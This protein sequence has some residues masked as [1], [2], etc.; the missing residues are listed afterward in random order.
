MIVTIKT[1][2]QKT[3][4]IELDDTENVAALKQ[5]IEQEQ[6]P[7]FPASSLKL[8]YAGKI[9]NDSSP[10]NEYN[11]QESN[12]VVVMVSKSKPAKTSAPSSE[13]T[14]S[15]QPQQQTATSGATSATPQE[16]SA[17][18]ESQV[19]PTEQPSATSAA[20]TAPTVSLSQSSTTSPADSTAGAISTDGGDGQSGSNW[21]SS[22]SALVRG[23]EY[24]AAVEN[25][26]SMGFER[27][28]VVRALRASFNN[29][30]RA[31][32]YLFNGIPENVFEDTSAPAQPQQPSQEQ[33]QPPAPMQ[34]PAQSGGSGQQ[35]PVNPGQATSGLPAAGQGGQ[36]GQAQGGVS[37]LQAL[38][39]HP[40][41]PMLRQVLH[42]NP[43]MLQPLL[44]QIGQTNPGLLQ[45]ISQNQQEFIAILNEGVQ[46][47]EAGQGDGGAMGQGGPM[48]QGGHG[49]LTTIQVTA[50]EKEA[51]DRLKALGFEETLAVQ[52][53]FACDKNEELAANFLLQQDNE[54]DN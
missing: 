39:N 12:F 42:Q 43:A 19:E 13:G 40:L 36:A 47:G 35:P 54:D 29:P 5:K 48:D 30:D 53:Y 3:F 51:I 6:G 52:A 25:M 15:S 31:V 8:I 2:Q 32:E 18:R 46:R 24:E 23:S 4:K 7:A 16:S 50:Q 11:I 14:S 27:Q 20:P 37:Q 34:I 17:S 38:R 22:A 1:L 33:P 49:P 9:L 10:L 26:M 28:L 21:I 45:L 41:F 44:Q